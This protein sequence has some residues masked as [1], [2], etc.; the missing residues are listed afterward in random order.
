MIRYI[1][2]TLDSDE[3][4]KLKLSSPLGVCD[5]IID[6]YSNDLKDRLTVLKQ[7]E[8]T[9]EKVEKQLNF[10]SNDME[11]DFKLLQDRLEN[12]FFQL[13]ERSDAF[14]DELFTLKNFFY[15]TSKKEEIAQRYK[16]EVLSDFIPSI[17][18]YISNLIDWIIDR[19]YRQ[20]KSITDFVIKRAK[21]SEDNLIGSLKNEFKFNRQVRI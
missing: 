12:I 3:R 2:E 11:K 7:D 15:L 4:I 1:L 21:V 14:F 17:D 5:R 19:K 10:Y 6:K 9:M 20:H 8:M 16:N 18:Q 13:K